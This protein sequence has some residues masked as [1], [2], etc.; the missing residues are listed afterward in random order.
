MNRYL[1]GSEEG[2]VRHHRSPCSPSASTYRLAFVVVA[3]V[4]R[5]PDPGSD[6]AE[7]AAARTFRPAPVGCGVVGWGAVVVAEEPL[8]P[9]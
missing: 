7:P 4:S 3:S 1:D 8:P 6:S 5:T 9:P 2:H